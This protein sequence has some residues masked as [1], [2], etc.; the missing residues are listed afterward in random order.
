RLLPAGKPTRLQSTLVDVGA[1]LRLGK[2]AVRETNC[3]WAT[4][5]ANSA[6]RYRGAGT[7]CAFGAADRTYRNG[8]CFRL[9]RP[10]AIVSDDRAGR[11]YL[12]L[13]GC[14]V[15]LYFLEGVGAHFYTLRLSIT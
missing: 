13:L 5:Q 10:S 8:V 4:A 15:P 12:D 11:E 7:V 1:Q 2:S 9:F 3:L 14:F 6:G